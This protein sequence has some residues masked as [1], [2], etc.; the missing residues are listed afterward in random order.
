M[1]KDPNV[2]FDQVCLVTLYVLYTAR[3]AAAAAGVPR[4]KVGAAGS[5]R[6]KE[7]AGV[8]A[9]HG[10]V[11]AAGAAVLPPPPEAGQPEASTPKKASA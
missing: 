11:A 7:S 2:H 3:D 9:P 6:G 4:A 5:T 10:A 1:V 8:A